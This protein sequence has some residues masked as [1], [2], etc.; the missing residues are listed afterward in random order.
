MSATATPPAPKAKKNQWVKLTKE[1]SGKPAGERIKLARADAESLVAAQTAVASESPER[2]LIAKAA[3]AITKE[4]GGAYKTAAAEAIEAIT[5]GVNSA[6]S[7]FPG[8]AG[9]VASNW[10]VN[11]RPGVDK[12]GGLVP[13]DGCQVKTGVGMGEFLCDLAD[14]GRKNY[15]RESAQ[16]IEKTWGPRGSQSADKLF[17]GETKA[18]LA[19]SSGATGGYTVPTEFSMRLM[20]LAMQQSVIRPRATIIPMGA[21]S[22]QIPTLD[23]TGT[24]AAG[25]TSLLAGVVAYWQEEAQLRVETEPKFR[26]I[27]LVAH[28]LTG[29]TKASNTL[30]ADS[31]VAL[32]ALLTRLFPA[33]IAW[34]TDY[35]FFNGPGGGQPQGI[36]PAACTIKVSRSTGGTFKLPDAATMLSKLLTTSM[37]SSV[38]V[39][40]QT[41]I[42]Q[43]VQLADASG[44]VVWIPNNSP[45]GGSTQT[46]PAT[47]F[48][49][50]IIFSEKLPALGTTGDVLLVD[51]SYYL[52]GD[53]MSIEIASS[54]HVAFTTNQTV[55]RFLSRVDGQPWLKTALTLADGVTQVSPFI[56]LV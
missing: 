52:I 20:S 38:W 25:T 43:L 14:H 47:L 9:S 40:S 16:H 11:T 55:W 18:A 3:K 1:W 8:M 51:P 45:T 21:R 54:I 4:I 48:G 35:A 2:K 30:M 7:K 29:Y 26:Q 17:G 12:D 56:C 15:S 37:G 13:S 46:L 24:P 50:P 42:P 28:E 19:E 36:I 34:H 23:Q 22:I 33:A 41:L 39:M 31:A 5:K 10:D 49:L 32:D 44:K 27:E 53:R 6:K